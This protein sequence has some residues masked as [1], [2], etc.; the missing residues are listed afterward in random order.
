MKL[1]AKRTFG[2]RKFYNAYGDQ[3]APP[4]NPS[5][6]EFLNF[7]K[8][9]IARRSGSLDDPLIQELN[10]AEAEVRYYAGI[11]CGLWISLIASGASAVIQVLFIGLQRSALGKFYAASA[12]FVLLFTVILGLFSYCSRLRIL[13]S[14]RFLRLKE[15]D[16]VYDA[17]YLLG[18]H[19]APEPEPQPPKS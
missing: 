4:Y 6:K 1:L 12:V 3:L 15:V 14:F 9:A 18:G 5:G 7:C 19:K 16:T 17:F 10:H 2:I 13:R 11:Y 8:L